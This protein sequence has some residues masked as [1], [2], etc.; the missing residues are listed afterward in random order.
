[1]WTLVSG[2]G[3]VNASRMVTWLARELSVRLRAAKSFRHDASPARARLNLEDTDRHIAATRG[4]VPRRYLPPPSR[5]E[6]LDTQQDPVL[7][8]SCAQGNLDLP[9]LDEDFILER[10]PSGLLVQAQKG[11]IALEH[12]VRVLDVDEHADGMVGTGIPLDLPEVSDV[13]L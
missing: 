12:A 5:P 7:P 6:I 3:P 9:V 1:P 13:D 10:G 8:R 11:E 4:V 2:G